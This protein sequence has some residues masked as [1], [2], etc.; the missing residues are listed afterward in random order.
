MIFCLFVQLFQ[1]GLCL[2]QN[3]Q[4]ITDNID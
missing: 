4:N 2:Y 1:V 3:S